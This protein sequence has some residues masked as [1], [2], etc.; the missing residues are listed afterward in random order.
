MSA[1]AALWKQDVSITTADSVQCRSLY[2]MF[3]VTYWDLVAENVIMW[4]ICVL[5][6]GDVQSYTHCIQYASSS[7]TCACFKCTVS[8]WCVQ[9]Q[10]ARLLTSNVVPIGCSLWASFQTVQDKKSIVCNENCPTLSHLT[11]RFGFVRRIS[12]WTFVANSKSQRRFI[13]APYL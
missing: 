8:S 5:T 10:S 4:L 7:R 13:Y 12:K 11:C 9:S 2:T 3:R 1:V 6:D